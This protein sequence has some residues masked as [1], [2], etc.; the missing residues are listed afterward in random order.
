MKLILKGFI[1]IQALTS[2]AFIF[3]LKMVLNMIYLIK[4][5]LHT[6]AGIFTG[7]YLSSSIYQVDSS[8]DGAGLPTDG[9]MISRWPTNLK[10]GTL[11][12]D[13]LTA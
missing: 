12:T 5:E 7:I 9:K 11:F 10:I 1:L 2:N 13:I 8:K 3:V 6:D 4:L